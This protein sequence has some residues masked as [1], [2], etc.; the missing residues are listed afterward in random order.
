MSANPSKPPF[1]ELLE[2]LK[3]ELPEPLFT[4]VTSKLNSYQ[5]RLHYA[6]LKIQVHFAVAQSLSDVGRNRRWSQRYSLSGFANR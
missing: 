1:D 4:A 6:E 3:S 5:N 2:Q